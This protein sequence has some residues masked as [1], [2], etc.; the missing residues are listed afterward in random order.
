MGVILHGG[1]GHDEAAAADVQFAEAERGEP[2]DAGF[3]HQPQHG[4]V[5]E[6]AAVVEVVHAHGEQGLET[7]VLRRGNGGAGH[8]SLL[9]LVCGAYG[10]CGAAGNACVALGGIPV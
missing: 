3:V 10:F 7:D 6:V 2:A 8:G 4:V 1:G 5:G 9:W